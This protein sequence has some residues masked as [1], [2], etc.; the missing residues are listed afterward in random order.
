MRN[1]KQENYFSM[2]F[3]FAGEEAKIPAA[4]DLYAQN[5]TDLSNVNRIL[6]L[7]DIK[8]FFDKFPKVNGWDE[9]KYEKYKI[10]SQN[11][12]KEVKAFFDTIGESNLVE[13]YENCDVTFW[14]D[15]WL[16]FYQFRVYERIS[17][18]RFGEITS[19]LKM[20]P[21]KML[22]NKHFVGFFSEQILQ[23]LILPEFGAPFL[24]NYFLSQRTKNEKYYLPHGITAEQI[25]KT[26]D[27]YIDS[28]EHINA[29]LL[30][31]IINSKSMDSKLFSIDDKLRYKAKKRYLKFWEDN[32]MHM[33]KSE[34]GINIS[35]S[36]DNPEV[37]LVFENNN[38]IAQYNSLW[39]K[40]NQ[41]YPTLLNNFIYLFGYV[42]KHMRCTLTNATHERGVFEDIFSVNGNGMYKRG[43]VFQIMNML[44]NAQMSCYIN[45]LKGFD[46]Y[47]EEICKW[48]FEEYLKDEF[49]AEGFICNFPKKD[50]SILE[51]CKLMASAMDGAIKQYKL[52]VEDGMIDRGLYEMSSTPILFRDLP[53]FV[54]NKYAYIVDEDLMREMNCLFSDQSTL[55]YIEKTK[56]EYSTLLELLCKEQVT[57]DDFRNYQIQEIQWLINQGSLYIDSDIIKLNFERVLT[58]KQFYS[59]GYI[60]LQ[61]YESSWLKQMISEKKV[62]V[63]SGLLSEPE[64][65]YIDYVLNK[66]EYSNGLDLR[67]KYIHD[68]ISVDENRQSQD[69]A[70]L[71]KIMIILIIKINEEFCLRELY[72]EGG[73]DFY[74]L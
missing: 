23:Q 52:F 61:Y 64:Y 1:S 72:E 13:V 5:K 32:S 51:K 60:C 25:Y 46:I 67:N 34:T 16:F 2:R 47:L 29:N 68:S 54:K 28:E 33:I 70:I 63:C 48:F 71:M 11:V 9:D 73:V 30:D 12:V 39:I 65:Q 22:E 19:G 27:S 24:I 42:D 62:K 56:S 21:N 49:S 43:Q 53:S 66:R 59:C 50:S 35:F 10:S 18:E 26:I 15:F 41:D 55:S 74:E 58:L 8:Q 14:D 3:C 7:Y 20:S 37:E 4:L 38:V 44:A 40:E 36:S 69:Y 17:K 45:V 57:L 6:E 31:L